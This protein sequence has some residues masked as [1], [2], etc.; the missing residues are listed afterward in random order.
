MLGSTFLLI[1]ILVLGTCAHLLELERTQQGPFTLQHV[2]QTE[3]EWTF[4]NIC[5]AIA[6]FEDTIQQGKLALE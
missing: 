2:L 4:Q 5:R 6:E 3:E 1:F